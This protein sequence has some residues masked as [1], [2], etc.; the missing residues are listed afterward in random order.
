MSDAEQNRSEQAT[1]YKLE[2]ARQKGTVSRSAEWSMVTA[3]AAVAMACYWRGDA[4]ARQ[5]SRE[6]ARALLAAG[7]DAWLAS[8]MHL[9]ATTAFLMVPVISVAILGAAVP[10]L[11]QTRFLFAPQALRVDWTRVNPVKG[12]R[13]IFSKET[14]VQGLKG[15]VKLL[16]YAA[17]TGW[18]ARTA[19]QGALQV[20]ATAADLSRLLAGA[21]TRLVMLLLSAALVF[22]VADRLW[23]RHSFMQSMRMSR[24]EQREEMRQ[25]E[26]DPRIRARRRQ[27]QRELVKHAQS[28]RNVRDADFLV[29]NPTHFAVG[30]RYRPEQM[31]APRVVAKGGG[32]LARRLRRLAFI[33]GVPVVESRALARTLFYRT[34][35][36]G[37]VPSALYADTANVYLQ[38]RRMRGGR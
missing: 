18:V 26:G 17:I 12:F 11:L 14:L 37:E 38:S 35:L 32:E 4:W 2:R 29:T 1:P 15:I 19:M 25:R 36:D 21:A 5:F 3:F 7:Q 24:R 33:Y 13:R 22:A 8:S 31:S 34:P 6:V 30:L 20:P 16:V 28:L 27:V 23:V 10:A 9:L